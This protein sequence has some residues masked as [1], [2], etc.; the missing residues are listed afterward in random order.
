MYYNAEARSF[1]QRV[2][3]TQIP[4]AQLR[5]LYA[6]GNTRHEYEEK[7]LYFDRNLLDVPDKDWL[8]LLLDEVLHPFYVWQVSATV[9]WILEEYYSLVYSPVVFAVE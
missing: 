6:Q 5:Q 1:E 4:P 7:R 8:T 3:N 9:L 2:F